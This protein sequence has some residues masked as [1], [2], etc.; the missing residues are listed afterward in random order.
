MREAI[1]KYRELIARPKSSDSSDRARVDAYRRVQPLLLERKD[2]DGL[3]ALLRQGMRDYPDMGCFAV[4]YAS[5]Q[6]LQRGDGA[7]A[8]A[9]LDDAA[10]GPCD[11]TRGRGVRSL[12]Y[13]V[14]WAGGRR[15]PSCCTRPAPSRR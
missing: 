5:F 1:A 12:A 11:A 15:A 8:L 10:V 4:D 7:A 6:V 9:T 14:R 13:Y 2:L 3:E